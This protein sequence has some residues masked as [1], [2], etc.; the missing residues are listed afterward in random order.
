MCHPFTGFFADMDLR[1][2]ILD[3]ALQKIAKERE[4]ERERENDCSVVADEAH[5]ELKLT[6]CKF[7]LADPGTASNA[8]R[9]SLGTKVQVRNFSFFV[10]YKQNLIL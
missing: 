3:I 2:C 6:D 4:R 9:A 7:L 8:K 1:T 10:F 5:R